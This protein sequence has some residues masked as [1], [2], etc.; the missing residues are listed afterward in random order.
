MERYGF[1]FKAPVLA[2]RDEPLGAV[3][4]QDVAVLFADIVGFT[5]MAERMTPEAVVTLLRQ[6]HERMTAQIFA[7]GVYRRQRRSRR[8]HR[9]RGRFFGVAVGTIGGKANFIGGGQIGYNW[10]QSQFRFRC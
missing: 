2:E 10:Q 1:V 4:R 3:R 7:C 8:G 6:F 5:R 9:D